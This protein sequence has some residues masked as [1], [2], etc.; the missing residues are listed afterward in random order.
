MTVTVDRRREHEAYDLQRTCRLLA[1]IADSPVGRLVTVGM[2]AIGSNS[3][4]VAQ[5]ERRTRESSY[6]ALDPTSGRGHDPLRAFATNT[7]TDWFPDAIVHQVVTPGLWMLLERTGLIADTQTPFLVIPAECEKLVAD[8]YDTV[9]EGTL[10][11]EAVRIVAHGPRGVCL[12]T[13]EPER[14]R[15]QVRAMRTVME[16][17]AGEDALSLDT[18]LI[19][20]GMIIHEAR[21]FA[22]ATVAQEPIGSSLDSEQIAGDTCTLHLPDPAPEGPRSAVCV[23]AGGIGGILG[24]FGIA[25]SADVG[26]RITLVDGDHVMP[27]NLLLGRWNG[28][29]KVKALQAE[30]QRFSALCEIDAIVGMVDERTRLP[31]A[32]IYYAV[33]DSMQS[34]A[35][36]RAAIPAESNAVLV[37]SGSSVNG[38]EAFLAGRGAACVTCRFPAAAAPEVRDECSRNQTLF[39]SNMIAAGLALALGRRAG[40]ED[41]RDSEMGFSRFGASTLNPSRFT[42]RL[43]QSCAHYA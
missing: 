36:A 19:A 8:A 10:S 3:L 12:V 13:P 33:T 28:V 22:G 23:G 20:A 2:S 7:V 24:I 30:M 25:P 38:A 6:L 35:L 16:G 15:E 5:S 4:M 26:Q 9:A 39:A 40:N 27:H 17:A 41:F 42:C 37:C 29:P 32:D 18:A 34:R 14:C 21:L 43:P 1:V 11:P 31:E